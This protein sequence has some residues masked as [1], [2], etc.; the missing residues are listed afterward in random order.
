V[1]IGA[2]RNVILADAEFTSDMYEVL[3]AIDTDEDRAVAQAEAVAGLPGRDEIRAVLFHDFVENPSG[4]SV[5]QVGAVRRAAERL[6]G[7][8]IEVAYEESSGDP[9]KTIIETARNRDVD[10]ICVA[11][12]KR[13]PAGKAL[14]G[15]V[16]QAVVLNADR[17]VLV[18]GVE[19]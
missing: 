5:I 7:A 2:T 3:L 9:A 8:G 4:A 15:S 13:T 19:K 16:T 17:P 10:C 14:F 11:G 1:P 12:R 6:E 18:T